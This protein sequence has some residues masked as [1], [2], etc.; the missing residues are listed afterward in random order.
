MEI[1]HN[2]ESTLYVIRTVRGEWGI[3]RRYF[4]QYCVFFGG[5]DAKREGEHQ[6]RMT[7]LWTTNLLQY[8]RNEWCGSMGK[9]DSPQALLPTSKI[10]EVQFGSSTWKFILE[11]GS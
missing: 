9:I 10:R 2:G 3:V 4:N 11:V 5:E 8:F 6:L 7:A 1:V